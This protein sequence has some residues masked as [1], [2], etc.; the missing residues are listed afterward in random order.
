[1]NTTRRRF[2]REAAG[3][4]IAAPFIIPSRVW[5][6]PP[7]EKVNLA[8]VGVG[9]RG[10]SVIGSIRACKNSQIVALCDVDLKCAAR[11][12]QRN[13]HAQTFRDFR[14]MFDKVAKDIDAVTIATPDH[15]HFPA[16]MHA[17]S[18]GKHVYVEKPLTHSFL[19]AEM[20]MK[21]ERKFGVVTQMG[22]Q[23]HTSIASL[24]F[25]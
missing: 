1:M 13:P 24:Q 2:I 14:R 9:G 20:L 3:S 23:G 17:M 7:S 12:T 5:A 10:G 6:A 15:T 19:E 21:A 8:C 22:N 4:V 18:L 11:Q 16:A 25:K